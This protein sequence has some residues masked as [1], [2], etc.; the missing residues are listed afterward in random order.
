MISSPFT[1]ADVI[2]ENVAR[3]GDGKALTFDGDTT[4][5]KGLHVKTSRVGNVLIGCGVGH[6]DRVAVLAYNSP[7]VYEVLLG[8]SKVGAVMVGLN[9]RLA[10]PEVAVIVADARPKVILY[11]HEHRHLL[12]DDLATLDGVSEIFELTEQFVALVEA[13]DDKDPELPSKG[14]DVVLQ[15]YTSGTTGVPKGVM[16]TNDNL[17]YLGRLSREVSRVS[18]GDVMLVAMPLFHIGGI[19]GLI[20]ATTV[21]AHAVLL[22]LPDPKAMVHAIEHHRV[23]HT[24]MVPAAIDSILQLD[25]VARADLSSLKQVSYGAS[26]ISDTLLL[27]AMERFGCGFAHAYGLTE[28]TGTVTFLGPDEHDPMGAR[29]HL[30]RS[31]GR[32]LPWVEL[33]IVDPET[34]RPM[35]TGHV[36]EVWVRSGVTMKGYW[37]KATE[38]AETITEEGWLRTGDAALLD[39]DGYLYIKDRYKDMIISG[40]ENIYPTEVENVLYQHPDILEVAVIAVPHERWGETVKAVVVLRSGVKPDAGALI[41]FART[42]LAHYKCPTS[43]SFVET[44]PRGGSGKVM[45]K[46]LR[47]A[48]AA[49]V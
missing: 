32:A 36:G 44:L 2:R 4:T 7:A 28:T 48:F 49:P 11:D 31:C 20:A 1:L 12:P 19:S 26:P 41:G 14:E 15:T 13:A 17:S 27:K 9:W 43:V 18:S 39:D 10:A 6:G 5:F 45:K 8:C 25:E 33:A 21:G 30:L 35:S 40:G 42:R 37:N 46:E 47:M 3:H 22:R 16:L 23:T 38:T 29:S 34:K 24:F